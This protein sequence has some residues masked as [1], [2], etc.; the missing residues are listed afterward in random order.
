[1]SDIQ[2]PWDGPAPVPFKDPA[3]LLMS[4][5][6]AMAQHMAAMSPSQPGKSAG[7]LS[8]F[9]HTGHG[10]A[11]E[12]VNRLDPTAMLSRAGDQIWIVKSYDGEVLGI[13]GPDPQ[14]AWEAAANYLG[15]ED[16]P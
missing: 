9:F 14:R 10:R 3:P 16:T 11:M 1:M 4:S 13:G 7:P 8:A 6:E 2:S 12:A 15:A 5:D